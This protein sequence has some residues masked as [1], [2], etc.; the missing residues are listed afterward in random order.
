[1]V[2]TETLKQEVGVFTFVRTD[3]DFSTP[4]QSLERDARKQEL[5]VRTMET[6]GYTI[7]LIG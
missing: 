6:L 3:I 7:L 5:S 2:T 4:R 1:M